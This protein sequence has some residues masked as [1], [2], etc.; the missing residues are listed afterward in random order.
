MIACFGSVAH[1]PLGLMLMVA[2]MT[3]T[4]ALLRPAMVALG[5]ATLVVGDDTI[6]KSQLR[7]RAD[8]PAHRAAFGL[9]LLS[10]VTVA[11][12]MT[13][14]R[15]I[16]PIDTPVNEA[17]RLLTSQNLPGA[18]VVTADGELVG[19]MSSDGAHDETGIS[20]EDSADRSYPNRPR[21]PGP[22]LRP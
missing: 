15:L 17:T 20:T 8:A 13:R 2:E 1:A 22:G 10:T 21:R 19:I 3:G 7:S 6:Y 16:L 9:S 12:V 14:P 4:L 11:D 5:L 18:P